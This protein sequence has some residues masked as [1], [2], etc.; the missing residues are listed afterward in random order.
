V[1]VAAAAVWLLLAPR[2]ALP[3]GYLLPALLVPGLCAGWLGLMQ[4]HQRSLFDALAGIGIAAGIFYGLV[5]PAY[6]AVSD[7][8]WGILGAEVALAVLL[9]EVAWVR[10]R[11]ADWRRAQQA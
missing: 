2:P 1:G 11:G 6:A 3:L 7:A 4:Q 8:P 5:E 10:W 9:R